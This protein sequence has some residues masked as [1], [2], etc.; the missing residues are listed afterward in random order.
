MFYKKFI[1]TNNMYINVLIYYY[2]YNYITNYDNDV[3]IRAYNSN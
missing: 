1:N 2:F 3:Y